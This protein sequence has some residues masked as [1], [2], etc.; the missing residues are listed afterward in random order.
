MTK[1]LAS[2]FAGA[3]ISRPEHVFQRVIGINPSEP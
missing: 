2:G 1:L 3:V